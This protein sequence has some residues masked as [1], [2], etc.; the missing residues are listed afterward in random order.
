M[1]IVYGQQGTMFNKGKALIG[2]SSRPRRRACKVSLNL[3][4]QHLWEDSAYFVGEKLKIHTT[5]WQDPHVL[6]QWGIQ[7]DFNIF[8]AATGLLRF[9]QNPQDTY[10]EL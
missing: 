6:E 3:D 2:M 10:E 5:R 9:T 8:A 1:N 7:E 4:D